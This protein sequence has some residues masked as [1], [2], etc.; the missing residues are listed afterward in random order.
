MFLFRLA[1]AIGEWNVDKLA[2]EMTVPMLV[3]WLAYFRLEPFGDE[4]RRTGRL[5][6]IVA[7]SSGAKV[8][9]ELEEKFLPGGGIYRGK[10]QTEQQML[11][12]LRK[13][14]GFENHRGG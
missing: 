7:A 5:A 8:E 10:N 13:I 6:T 4:W 1:L 11:D 2:Q 9:G 3:D 12:E 14:P